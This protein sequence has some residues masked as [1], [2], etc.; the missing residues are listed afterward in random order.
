MV[1]EAFNRLID[2]ERKNIK[3]ITLTNIEI[4]KFSLLVAKK[5]GKIKSDLPSKNTNRPKII[6]L[7]KKGLDQEIVMSK[8]GFKNF[9]LMKKDEN[10]EASLRG[11]SSSSS[12]LEKRTSS[13][14][15]AF[16]YYS[17]S[18]IGKKE[19]N[20]NNNTTTVDE[21]KCVKNEGLKKRKL[22]YFYTFCDKKCFC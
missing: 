19:N 20:N 9:I 1:I 17:N 7:K 10:M 8:T 12:N 6:L 13:F 16:R 2:L 5:N 15:I 11:S 3:K 14:D 18:L 22:N 4:A 21:E